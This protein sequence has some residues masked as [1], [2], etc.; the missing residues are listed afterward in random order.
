M[1]ECFLLFSIRYNNKTMFFGWT[2]DEEERTIVSTSEQ[3]IWRDNSN[4]IKKL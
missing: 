2:A 3:A 1:Q 4:A